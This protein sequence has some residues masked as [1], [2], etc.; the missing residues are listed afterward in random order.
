MGRAARLKKERQEERAGQRFN[1][2]VFMSE[3]D[4]RALKA[5]PT[6]RTLFLY[7]GQQEHVGESERQVF[8]NGRVPD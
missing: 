4:I 1:A 8:I 5:E 6:T 3:A 2:V 7:A